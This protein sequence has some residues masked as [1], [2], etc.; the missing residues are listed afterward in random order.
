MRCNRYKGPDVGS[1][2]QETGQ[3]VPFYHPRRHSWTDHFTLEE[4][5]V[6]PLTAEA[7]VTIQILS[8]NSEE[9]VRERQRLLEAGLYGN[10]IRGKI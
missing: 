7:R 8:I 10:D 6:Q 3:L 5:I 1:F 4:A 2:D 9:R